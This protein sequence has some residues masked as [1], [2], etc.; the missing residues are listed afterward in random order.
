VNPVVMSV[1]EFRSEVLHRDR[2]VSRIV[3]ES[4]IVLKGDGDDLGTLA[5]EP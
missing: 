5:A 4:K 3:K 2:F 1:S